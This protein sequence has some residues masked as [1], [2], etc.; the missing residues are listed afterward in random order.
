MNNRLILLA[1]VV[2]IICFS[3]LV[4]LAPTEHF[5][6]PCVDSDK[7]CSGDAIPTY[8][9]VIIVG[10]FMLGIH[11]VVGGLYKISEQSTGD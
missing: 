11:L 10:S 2:I 7:I 5:E 9:Q 3:I 6:R 8:Y 4:K 1:I